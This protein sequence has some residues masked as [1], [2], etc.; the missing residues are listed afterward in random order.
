MGS[1]LDGPPAFRDSTQAATNEIC[2]IGAVTVLSN[3]I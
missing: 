3:G 2:G 1:L